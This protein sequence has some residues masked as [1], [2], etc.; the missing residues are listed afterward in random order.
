MTTK[1]HRTRT[2]SSPKDFAEIGTQ[3]TT[4]RWVRVKRPILSPEAD[5]GVGKMRRNR[6]PT[7]ETESD[8]LAWTFLQMKIESLQEGIKK[9]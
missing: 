8:I 1:F 6:S 4:I 5:L 3:I 2:G 7:A 9:K